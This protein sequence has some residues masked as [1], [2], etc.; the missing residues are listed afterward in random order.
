M[1]FELFAKVAVH[2]GEGDTQRHEKAEQAYALGCEYLQRAKTSPLVTQAQQQKQHLLFKNALKCFAF[3][4]ASHRT[5]AE[6][7]VKAA[8]I[9]VLYQQK[10][11]AVNYLKEALRLSPR[12]A[13]A[14]ELLSFCSATSSGSLPLMN[15]MKKLT[16]TLEKH[17]QHW[18]KHSDIGHYEAFLGDAFEACERFLTNLE[19]LESQGENVESLFV[20]YDL[21]SAAFEQLDE[22]IAHL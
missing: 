11:L 13:Q 19:T 8:Y 17:Y 15:D 20:A 21:L 10:L 3:A 6:P 7:Y 5:Y 18:E 22:K 14:S 12:H 1:D 9:F 16:Q 4:I 2:K